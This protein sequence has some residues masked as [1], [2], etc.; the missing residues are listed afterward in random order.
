MVCENG[1]AKSETSQSVNVRWAGG[2][3]G[4]GGGMRGVQGVGKGLN[5]LL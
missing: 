1:S 2:V 3:E 5:M 4:C